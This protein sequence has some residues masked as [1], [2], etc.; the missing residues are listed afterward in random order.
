[1][2]TTKLE[3]I[4][5]FKFKPIPLLSLIAVTLLSARRIKMPKLGLSGLKVLKILHLITACLWLGGAVGL[6]L[7]VFL[8][9]K[10]DSAGEIY[11][12]NI[13]GKLIDDLVI[14]PGAIGCL[15]TG[16]IYS[17]FSNWG[18][19]KQRWLLI[20][21]ILT[22]YCVLFGTF[23]LGPKINNQP[24][25]AKEI[26]LDALTNPTYLSHLGAL[27][28]GGLIQVCILIFMIYLSVFKPKG[29][30]KNKVNES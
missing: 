6:Y 17:L 24:L 14:I 5:I 10:G 3:K 2:D 25:I 13:A 29:K 7:I 28:I 26:G 1:M 15:L 11:G 9:T 4:S 23:F 20:K 30:P 27:T 22:V 21:W 19:F 16:L 8:L 12:Y 18:F